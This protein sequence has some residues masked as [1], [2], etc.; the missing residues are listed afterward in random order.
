MPIFEVEVN[1]T[2][3]RR[4]PVKAKNEIEAIDL[5]EEKY[6]TSEIVLDA[7]DYVGVE[8]SAFAGQDENKYKEMGLLVC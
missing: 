1:E 2:L 4:V 8:F 6:Y 5:V 3:T 7:E